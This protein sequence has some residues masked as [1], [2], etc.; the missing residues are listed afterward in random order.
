MAEPMLSIY[1]F[2]VWYGASHAIKDIS[3]H[4]NQG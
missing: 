2:N 3:F 4:V 1:N